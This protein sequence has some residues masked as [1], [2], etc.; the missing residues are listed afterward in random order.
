MDAL[1]TNIPESHI[2]FMIEFKMEG[3]HMDKAT[4]MYDAYHNW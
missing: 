2:H 3:L 4:E 1:G